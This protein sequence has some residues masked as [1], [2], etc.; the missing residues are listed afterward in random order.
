MRYLISDIGEGKNLSERDLHVVG[1]SMGAK[2]FR[3]PE[4]RGGKG[5][6]VKADVF[7]FG[8]L[9]CK[10]LD[11]RDQVCG[12]AQDKEDTS[13]SESTSYV[14]S[15]PERLRK[16]LEACMT[17]EPD[18]RPSMRGVIRILD[19]FSVV[20]LS[21]EPVMVTWDW[22]KTLADARTHGNRVV[23]PDEDYGSLASIFM[24]DP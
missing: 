12:D 21:K 14:R 10:L 23:A 9:A 4:I 18:Q 1:A 24:S 22:N 15:I 11:L 2:Q 16:P 20:L 13:Q 6:T 3:A 17:R 8:V 7:A 5:W 19:D